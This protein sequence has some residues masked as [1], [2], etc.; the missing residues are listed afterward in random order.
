MSESD[1]IGMVKIKAANI[2]K[3]LQLPQAESYISAMAESCY[4]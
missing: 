2:Q 3:L 4:G 1:L